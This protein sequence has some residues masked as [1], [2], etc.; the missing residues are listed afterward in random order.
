MLAAILLAWSG[1]Q[2]LPVGPPQD[3]PDLWWFDGER[4]EERVYPTR[5]ELPCP[6]CKWWVVEGP[7]R[8]VRRGGTVAVECVG[9]SKAR[10]DVLL[11]VY[12]SRRLWLCRM[13]VRTPHRL[14]ALGP[15]VNRDCASRPCRLGDQQDW[16]GYTT[17]ISYRVLDQFGHP[18]EYDVP[19]NEEWASEVKADRPGANWRRGPPSGVVAWRGQFADRIQGEVW[20]TPISLTRAF[21]I[22][23][24][25]FRALAGGGCS[26]GEKVQ[27]WVQ[28][29][30]V[31]SL[32][33]GRG[34]LVQ[35]NTLQRYT[36]HACHERIRGG[37]GLALQRERKA[38]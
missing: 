25:S 30:R 3:L 33:P 32:Q 16:V 8:V 19:I 20:G 21:A 35:V 36:T 13:T 28:E 37:D 17:L 9:P 2:A 15:P 5:L 34:R 11:M 18:M 23:A 6:K 12:G 29:W 24:P 7:A 1:L 38:R 31:G 27:S 14:A 22:P 26:G 4:P 10:N